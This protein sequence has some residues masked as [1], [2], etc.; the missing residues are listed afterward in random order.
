[1]VRN[2]LRK[3]LCQ[4]NFVQSAFSENL[5]ELKPMAQ[6]SAIPIESPRQMKRF[7]SSMR[8]L[9]HTIEKAEQ[10]TRENGAISFPVEQAGIVPIGRIKPRVV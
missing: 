10:L 6:A 2:M 4:P 7:L 1:M 8:S 3:T 9:C 5:S